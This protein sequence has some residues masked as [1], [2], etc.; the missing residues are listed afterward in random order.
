MSTPSTS[1]SEPSDAPEEAQAPKRTIAEIEADII[2][3][4]SELA[5]TVDEL[6]YRLDPR[7]LAKGAISDAKE[8]AADT[9]HHIE[10]VA[11]ETAHRASVDARVFAQDVRTGA[12]RALAIVGGVAVAVVL[13]VV[14]AI[15]RR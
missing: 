8:I 2:A 7:I 13:V 3:T 6:A 9:A 10:H 4:R 1:P 15:R 5:R 14:I 11:K 12:P